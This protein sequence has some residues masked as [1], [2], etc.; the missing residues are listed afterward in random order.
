MAASPA[1][2]EGDEQDTEAALERVR[3]KIVTHGEV[4]PDP[5][6]PCDDVEPSAP[7]SSRFASARS[8]N[9]IAAR[10]DR[11]H[12]LPWVVVVYQLE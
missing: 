8:S 11:R 12:S 4:Y 1:Q 10:I 3:K 6:R 5:E 7:T 2:Q 9:S